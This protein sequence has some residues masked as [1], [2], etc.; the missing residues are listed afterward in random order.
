MKFTLSDEQR[1]FAQALRDALRQSTSWDTLLAL[2]VHE[3]ESVPDL[4]VAF[5]ELGRAAVPGPVVE[6]FAV[7][8]EPSSTLAWPPHVPYIVDD[9]DHVYAIVHDTRYRAIL[10]D[11]RS[12]VDPAR[13]LH[14]Y[15]LGEAVGPI[16]GQAFD[17]GVLACSAQL[18]GL[19]RALLAR[20][21]DYAL[22]RKQFGKAIG[23]FQAVKH[24]LADVHVALELAEPLVFGAAVTMTASDVSAAKIAAGTAA[25]QAMRTAL[26]VHGA[27]GYT[28]EFEL[29]RWLL[30]VRALVTAWGTESF[31]RERLMAALCG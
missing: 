2:G 23:S 18:V 22:Q 20:T 11:A 25:Y 31:H 12:S 4:V 21:R 15:R 17:R 8:R 5:L 3:V 1:Q 16:D 6:S 9:A 13:Q 28:A 27:I 26:Q 24:H 10:E 19:G 30:K 29:S 7:L 14:E